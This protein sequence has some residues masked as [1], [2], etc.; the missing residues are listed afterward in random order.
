MCMILY[1]ERGTMITVSARLWSRVTRQ[2]G[3]W[4]WQGHRQRSGYGGLTVGNKHRLAHR[5]A[6]EV[7]YGPIP[8][9]LCVLHR[10][11]NPPCCNPAHLWLGTKAQNNADRAVKGRSAIGDRSGARLH[12]ETRARGDRHP[13]R[14]TPGW[15]QGERNGRARLTQADADAIRRAYVPGVV[16]QL[17]LAHQ[18]GV[19]LG[20]VAHIIHGRHWPIASG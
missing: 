2:D 17:D 15:G 5:V 14:Y 1:Y 20:A 11:D 12:P 18:Y 3:C 9:G 16:R 4:E 6:W 13:A 7:T 10:C 19:S 8:D